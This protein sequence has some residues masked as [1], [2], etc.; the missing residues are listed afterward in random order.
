MFEIDVI[1]EPTE[2]F[3]DGGVI[4]NGDFLALTRYD[5][6][7]VKPALLI[8][9]HVSLAT[10]RVDMMRMTQADAFENSRMPMR[11][12]HRYASLSRSRDAHALE[13][14]GLTETVLASRADLAPFETEDSTGTSAWWEQ[15]GAFET[16]YK[17]QIVLYRTSFATILKRRWEDLQSPELTPAI[18]AGLLNVEAW[19]EDES[20]PF[21]L[22]WTE[23]AAQ[24]WASAVNQMATRIGAGAHSLMLEPHAERRFKPL[25]NGDL[26]GRSSDARVQIATML[27]GMAPVLASMSVS[28]ILDVRTAAVDYLAPF[29]GEM[30][31]LADE[32]ASETGESTESLA[33]EV[34]W[35]WARDVQPALSDLEREM[36]A[37]TF[38]RHLVDSFVSDK[39]AA[40]SGGVAIAAGIG[41][42]F[43]GL[44]ALVPAGVAA[45]YPFARALNETLKSNAAAKSHK[46]YFLHAASQQLARTR[47]SR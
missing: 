38:G 19:N 36:R 13:I 14:L 6:A 28:E 8:A 21:S 47:R 15:V 31:K 7:L 10:A 43:A 22:S 27:V 35:R 32:I 41:T 2:A 44:G 18:E 30:L 25:S 5:E 9:D 29:R 33:A 46:F 17:E 20:D 37:G 24:Y 42:V 16:K 39:G 12:L 40:I 34:E 3:A 45:V 23:V 11:F 4:P 1:S 26:S